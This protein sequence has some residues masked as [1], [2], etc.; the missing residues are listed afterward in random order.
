MSDHKWQSLPSG[1]LARRT[2]HGWRVRVDDAAHAWPDARAL[3][4]ASGPPLSWASLS[5]S[6]RVQ[7]TRPGWVLSVRDPQHVWG[8]AAPLF[9]AADKGAALAS[10]ALRAWLADCVDLAPH[11]RTPVV[12]ILA[13]LRGHPD[14]R[15]LL[16]S[17]GCGGWRAV[18]GALRAMGCARSRHAGARVVVGLAL[19]PSSV[20]LSPALAAWVASSFRPLRGSLL[21]RADIERWANARA[22][23]IGEE[24]PL[25]CALLPPLCALG[26]SLVQRFGVEGIEGI[27]H[28]EQDSVIARLPAAEKRST[29]A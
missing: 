20:A 21:F 7:W 16:A 9:P 1:S 23:A 14:G 18:L 5:A 8:D 28:E 25:W 6:V 26:G 24:A 22:A 17:G 13:S 19:R 12:A 4:S 15:G 2:R 11:A 27:W 3:F 29:G 10:G